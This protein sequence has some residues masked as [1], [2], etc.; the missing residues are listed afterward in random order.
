MED[1]IFN[2]ADFSCFIGSEW[3]FISKN[4]RGSYTII[5][6]QKD[7][8]AVTRNISW[9]FYE[10]KDIP[11]K[12]VFKRLDD[13]NDAMDNDA[14]FSLTI[15]QLEKTAMKLKTDIMLE[16]HPVAVIYNFIKH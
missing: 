6:R 3:N 2:E 10:S 1:K 5:D 15:T 11:E 9:S 16:G 7:C 4:N 12:F 8:P 13:K 14:G